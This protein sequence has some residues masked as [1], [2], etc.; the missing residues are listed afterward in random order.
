MG[1]LARLTCCSESWGEIKLA[2]SSTSHSNP[3]FSCICLTASGQRAY[4]GALSCVS[5]LNMTLAVKV[6]AR[7]SWELM[8]AGRRARAKSGQSNDMAKGKMLTELRAAQVPL[9]VKLWKD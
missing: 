2:S 6:E 9:P 1:V 8:K 3:T 7:C 4:G 5:I